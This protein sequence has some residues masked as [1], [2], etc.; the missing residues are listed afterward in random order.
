M[1]S[2]YDVVVIGGGVAG[3]SAALA[4]ASRKRHVALIDEYGCAGWNNW[5]AGA[6]RAFGLAASAA[7]SYEGL[8][9]AKAYR[10]SQ[11]AG[12]RHELQSVGIAVIAG[13]ATF[14]SAD[15]IDAGGQHIKAKRFVIATGR[16]QTN[17]P[18]AGG[19][20]AQQPYQ[21][22]DLTRAPKRMIMIDP[23]ALEQTL[24]QSLAATGVKVTIVNQSDEPAQSTERTYKQINGAKLGSIE[25]L[26][27]SYRLNLVADGET[28]S[29]GAELIISSVKGSA[30]LSFAPDIA[31]VA[32]DDTGILVD[33]FLQ[34]SR[35]GIWAAGDCLAHNA[36]K[37]SAEAQ[38]SVA[39]LA[40]A[41]SRFSS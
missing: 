33:R 3:R 28:I 36:T 26:Q 16:Q 6:A 19:E 20:Y 24:A 39:G 23:G 5:L 32:C 22:F 10:Q 18:V 17:L 13:R 31:E 11:A 30:N 29:L 14:T 25:R 40:A 2:G 15:V 21:L 7:G 9:A 27:R 41:S 12:Y 37:A 34:T 38:G 4:V 8:V 1:T 35:R